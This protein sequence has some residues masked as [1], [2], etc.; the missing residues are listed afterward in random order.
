MSIID[1]YNSTIKYIEDGAIDVSEDI[2]NNRISICSSCHLYDVNRKKCTKCGCFLDIK[3]RW[4]TE[5]CPL[6]KWEELSKEEISSTS[7]PSFFAK[8]GGCGCNKNSV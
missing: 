4:A 3:A 7:N 5:S 6:G 8:P 1:L 2:F